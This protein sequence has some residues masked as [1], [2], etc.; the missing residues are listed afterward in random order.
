MAQ[1][2]PAQE[3]LHTIQVTLADEAATAR[4]MGDLGLLLRAGDIIALSGDLGA[5][6]TVAA[7]ALI[8]YLAGDDA[9]EVPSPSFTL[10]QPYDLPAMPVIHADFYRLSDPQE[11]DELGLV[12][13]PDDQLVIVEWPERAPHAFPFDRIDVALVPVTRDGAHLREATVTGYGRH[14]ATIKRLGAMRAAIERAG[15]ADAQRSRMAGDAST[16]SYARLALDGQHAIVMNMPRRPDGPPVHNGKPY[17]AV[18]HLAEDVRPFVAMAGAL[19]E[20][21]FSSP[22][23]YNGDLEAGFLVIEDLGHEVIVEG[24]PPQ[25]IVERYGAAV[26]MLAA[27]HWRKLPDTLKVGSRTTYT[28]PRYDMDAFLIEVSLLL[29]W[30]LPDHDVTVDDALR[31]EFFTLWGA[32]LRAPMNGPQ[33]WVL[34]DFHSPNIIWLPGRND[35]A[36]V[37]VLDFQDAVMGPPAYD[38]ASLLQD[39]RVDVPEQT[40][41]ALFARYIAARRQTDAEFDVA[42]FAASYAAMAAQRATKILGIFARLNRRD[43]KPHYLRHQPRVFGYVQRALAHPSLGPLQSWY[44]AHV[45]PPR[46]TTSS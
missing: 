23:L 26:E 1:S 3:H 33:S 20:E 4:L 19:R 29:D 43:G 14:A 16:R 17:S 11:L 21:G 35:S 25:P 32:A 44:Q 39:A 15:L 31:E 9:L 7:R 28:L 22:A 24:D 18:A 41:I 46:V 38:V 13:L 30:Y 36:R 45:P 37:G 27:L 42:G 2:D 40:E 5:G 6:K 12:P 8:R 34:R 10:V